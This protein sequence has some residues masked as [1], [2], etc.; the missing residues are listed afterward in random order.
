MSQYRLEQISDFRKHQ[1]ATFVYQQRDLTDP[2][3]ALDSTVFG[4]NVTTKHPCSVCKNTIYNCPCHDALIELPMPIIQTVSFDKTIR[5]ISNICPICSKLLIPND[6]LKDILKLNQSE[7]FG[8]C[9]EAAKR[10][11]ASFKGGQLTCPSCKKQLSSTIEMDTKQPYKFVP[12]FIIK[13]PTTADFEMLNPIYVYQV[14]QRFTQIEELGLSDCL[15]PKNFMTNYIVVIPSR[16][17]AK[18]LIDGQETTSALTTYYREIIDVVCPKLTEIKNFMINKNIIT[19]DKSKLSEFI[20]AYA[21]LEAYYKMITD[22]GSEKTSEQIKQIL[23]KKYKTRYDSNNCLINKFKGKGK[24]IMNKGMLGKVHDVSARIVL[25]PGEDVA[26]QDLVVPINMAN[27]LCIEYPVY[28]ENLMFMKNLI[29][30]M[31][32]NEIYTNQYIPKVIGVNS[33]RTGKFK[34][35]DQSSAQ[36]IAALLEPGDKLALSLFNHDF[37]I[38]NRHPSIREECLTTFQVRKDKISTVGIPLQTCGPKQADFDGDE[39]QVYLCSGHET[40]FES[41]LLHSPYKQLKSA[42]DGGLAYYYDG[43]HDDDLGVSRISDIDIIYHNHKKCDPINVLSIIEKLLPSDFNYHS[44]SLVIENGKINKKK[45]NFKNKEFYKYYASVCGN[46]ACCH[47]IDTCAQVGYDINRCYGA[48]LG[49]EVRFWCSENDKKRIKDEKEKA[50]LKAMEIIKVTG[51]PSY[52]SM[53]E[54]EKIKPGIKKI[55]IESAA[56]Q[57]FAKMGYTGNRSNEYFAMVINPDHVN[58]EGGPVIPSLAEGSRSNFGGYKYSFDPRDY[59]YIEHG[60]VDDISAYEHF[61]ITMEELKSIYIRTTSVASQGY[62]TNRMTVLFERALVDNNGCLVDGTT[63][64]SNQY[65]ICG[66]DSRLEVRLHLKD[67][68]DKDFDKKYSDKRLQQLHKEI[69]ENRNRYRGV[70][71]FIKNILPDTFITGFDFTQ[72]FIEKGKNKQEDIDKF[73]DRMYETFVPKKLQED[74]TQIQENFKSHE[75][76]FRIMFSEYKYSDKLADKIITNI[77]NMLANAGDPVGVKSALACSAPL[78]QAALNAVHNANSGGANVD[79][80]RRP[81]GMNAFEELLSGKKMKDFEIITITLYDDSEEASRKF[82]LE[83]ETFFY[84]DIWAVNELHVS[85]K[86]SDHLL[87]LYGENLQKEKRHNFYVIS[88]WNMV[89]LSGYNIKTS[90]VINAVMENYPEIRFMLPYVINKT[91]INVHIYFKEDTPTQRI[92][93]I[94]EDWKVR[95]MGN[96]I[97]G[98]YLMNCFVTELECNPGHFVIEANEATEDSKA[99]KHL[100]YDERVNPTK[101]RTTDPRRSVRMFGIC[102]GE[103]R[104]YEQLVF[105]SQ[106]LASTK[107]IACHNYMLLAAIQTADGNIVFCEATSMVKSKFGE[108]M[109]KLKFERAAMFIE[110]HLKRGNKETVNEFTSANIFCDLPRL[111]SS[112]N[113]YIL[114]TN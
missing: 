4:A 97:H 60:Y 86:I 16:L 88:T 50:L 19:I 90:D 57:N 18:S 65:G 41:L 51:K 59:G 47:M 30:S 27:K 45:C 81:D 102:E 93:R 84:S 89:R 36:I 91:Q 61:F 52:A 75:Y 96:I 5:L 33:I 63:L 95:D 3:K 49:F 20:Q 29:I 78:T 14:L 43:A 1:L 103:I 7:R 68:D 26:M 76:F 11:K 66:L 70:T 23:N 28:K 25:G 56:G 100:I 79:T 113:D 24:S 46:A 53:N 92:Y 58:V 44:S 38:Q 69:T 15:H 32:N 54:F 21:E 42:T 109:K 87:K 71:P 108:F 67:I 12:Y 77:E 6:R 112:V 37:I 2:D 40:D 105:T 82:A 17:R 34:S 62:M 114:Y 94:L 101:C 80:V 72:L 85:Q 9:I 35:F 31:T 64:L 10:Y 111:G 83:Q 74:I 39:I 99:L 48:S 55:L 98:K 73:I 110:D 8:T 22:D 106:N 107:V 13:N 104:H